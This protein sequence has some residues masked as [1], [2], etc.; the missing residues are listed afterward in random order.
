MT[1]LT[2]LLP[3]LKGWKFSF[4]PPINYVIPAGGWVQP[5]DSKLSYQAPIDGYILGLGATT[6]QPTTTLE[7]FHVGPENQQRL[8]TGSPFALN[9]AG[10]QYP[11]GAG[12]WYG[13]YNAILGIYTSFYSPDSRLGFFNDY[14]RIRILAPAGVA[15]VVTGY[16]HNIIEVYNRKEWRRSLHKL[17]QSNIFHVKGLKE[18]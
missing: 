4:Q 16:F 7:I 15:S 2:D 17:L 3:F 11:S 5:Y 6:N 10:V 9:A 13:T 1:V 8:I 14:L 18:V 12:W